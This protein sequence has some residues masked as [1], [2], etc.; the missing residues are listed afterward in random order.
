M[1]ESRR[2]RTRRWLVP[3]LL[4]V[5]W[6]VA[7]GTLGPLAGKLGEVVESGA[8]AYLPKSAEATQ[9]L[10][11]M[12]RFGEPE[13]MPA[14]LVYDAAGGTLSAADRAAVAT[15]VQRIGSTLGTHLA[16]PPIGPEFSRDG[17]AAR[18][19]L[20]FSGTDETK[21]TPFV[22]Q[23]RELIADRPGLQATS[24]ARRV[25]RPTSRTPSAP[26]T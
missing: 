4:L 10:D 23:L 22:E 24:P 17:A 20:L 9:V 2:V 11:L 19:V 21:I 18:V 8:A 14:V 25:S 13:A 16:V 12:Q 7:G 3:A 26:S 5:A 6:L 1:S 15:D